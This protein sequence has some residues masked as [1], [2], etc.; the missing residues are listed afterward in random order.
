MM[1]R[2]SFESA[3]GHLIAAHDRKVCA[4][5]D[6]GA[7]R[8]AHDY[9]KMHRARDAF[10]EA[11]DAFLDEVFAPPPPPPA[12]PPPVTVVVGHEEQDRRRTRGRPLC[13]RRWIEI[14]IV[15]RSITY[16]FAADV[17]SLTLGSSTVEAGDSTELHAPDFDPLCA[18]HSIRFRG[19]DYSTTEP[20]PVEPVKIAVAAC[21]TVAL[22]LLAH[23]I[24]HFAATRDWP[25]NAPSFDELVKGERA[26]ASAA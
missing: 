14:R 3:L 12:P 5:I 26:K 25:Q 10:A 11:H 18:G 20:G 9:D 8:T 23:G 24:D 16:T 15:W 17:D 22:H 19:L 21:R 13:W 2:D 1:D 4:E 6:A 7:C